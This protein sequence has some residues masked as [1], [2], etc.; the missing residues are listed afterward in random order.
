MSVLLYLFRLC[1]TPLYNLPVPLPIAS[2]V[3]DN[4]N[5]GRFLA[6]AI[7][8]ALGQGLAPGE[9][10]IVV[11]DDGSTDESREVLGRFA[12]KVEAV[13]QPN[14]GYAAAFNAGIARC[15]GAVVF[16]LDADDAWLEG[17]VRRVLD[18]F[19]R[20][21]DLVAVEHFQRDADGELRPLEGA[22]PAWPDRYALTDYLEGRCEF[23]ATS[24]LA[25]RR[26]AL[27][28]ALPIPAEFRFMYA[29]DYLLLAALLQGPVGNIPEP[30]G[31]H[32][33]HGANYYTGVLGD[34]RKM[35]AERGMR[36]VFRARRE[37]W[38]SE[39]GCKSSPRFERLER[40]E[41][42][43]REVLGEVYA[44]RRLAAAGA[45]A[46]GVAGHLADPF[47]FFRAATCALAVVHPRLYLAAHRAYAGAG[48]L[49]RLRER[50][51]PA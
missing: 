24:G 36:A 50:W 35:E 15:R 7:E 30:L 42:L 33:V 17:K 6:R 8:S 49:K 13:F 38:F 3:I 20:E 4:F 16:L 12:G 51:L 23:G 10:E 46:R 2:V 37:A 28:K 22:F 40:L 18:R 19:E 11:V 27:V 1:L 21:R 47:G 14:Q 25:F 26:E 32:R 39:R 5:Y 31:L 34:A 48:G 9:L 44:G 43:R 41:D 45:V 29:D